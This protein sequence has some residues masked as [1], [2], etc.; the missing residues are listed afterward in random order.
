M[1]AR[2]ELIRVTLESGEW[3]EWRDGKFFGNEK[4]RVTAELRSSY[5]LVLPWNQALY[6]ASFANPVGAI[7]SMASGLKSPEVYCDRPIEYERYVN[8]FES[9]F[10][11]W[12]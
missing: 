2:T 12:H 9:S 7:T 11:S 1:S 5:R 3:V 6:V 8:A 10:G 4:L